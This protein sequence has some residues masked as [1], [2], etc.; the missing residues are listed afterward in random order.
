M[1]PPRPGQGVALVGYRGTG[2]S[3]VGR[4]LAGRMNRE[5]IDV[6]LQIEVRSGRSI[7][8]I[9]AELG[10]PIFRDWEERTLAELLMQFPEAIVATGGGSVLR[11][12]NRR[13][14]REFGDIVWLTALP[15]ELA[16]RLLADDR[17]RLGRPALTPAGAIEEIA[18]VLCA[19]VPI[20]E[21]LADFVVETGGKGPEEVATSILERLASRNCP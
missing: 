16:R 6:D 10:E 11:E 18:Q 21:A 4:L 9:F 3:T 15:D 5:F 1:P 14:L 12:Q 2:K 19:R 7:E 8:A 20:Y 17:S 13:R